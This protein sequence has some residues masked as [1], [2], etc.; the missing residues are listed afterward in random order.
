M[1]MLAAVVARWE[2]VIGR[3]RAGLGFRRGPGE[4]GGYDGGIVAQ[5]AGALRRRPPPCEVI[6]RQ[7][8]RPFAV[9]IG[10]PRNVRMWGAVLLRRG[11]GLLLL[12]G[13][14]EAADFV[15]KRVAFLL[16]SEAG[17]AF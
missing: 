5:G 10:T 2:V 16:E 13:V 17:L 14:A 3:L 6:R 11:R 1:V 15:Q 4:D 8:S 12:P 9:I 7:Q